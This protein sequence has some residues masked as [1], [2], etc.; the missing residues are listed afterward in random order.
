MK[1]L[2]GVLA[3]LAVL[4][5]PLLDPLTRARFIN[6]WVIEWGFPLLL[7]VVLVILVV[8]F[9]AM[10]RVA[11]AI[12]I[13]VLGIAGLIGYGNARSYAQL[14]AYA[15]TVHESNDPMPTLKERAPFLVA[16]RQASSNL[17]G[18]NGQIS[19][20][21]YLADSNRYSTLVDRKG[22]GNPGYAAI[23]NQSIALTGQASGKPCLFDEQNASQRMDGFFGNS[24]TRAIAAK[25]SLLIATKDDAWGYCDG[26]VPKIVVPVT[27]LNGWFSPVHVPAG[28]A[29]YDGKTGNVEL[30]D[31]VKAGELPGPAIA[32][33]YVHRVNES[34]ATR[35]GDWWSMIMGQSGLT[36]EVKD[37]NDP[38]KDNPSAFSLA[39]KDEPGSVYASPFT[40]RAS[41]RSIEDI[42]LL[43]S[44][45]V[46]AGESPSVTLY[47]LE[48]PRQSNAATA[49]KIK[50]DYSDLNGWATGLQ[51]MEVIPVSHD[52]WAASIGLNQN[53]SYR[54]LVKTDGSS[55]LTKDGETLRCIDKDGKTVGTSTDP[56]KEPASTTAVPGEIGALSNEQLAQLQDAVTKEVL[57]RLNQ[58]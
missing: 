32:L 2:G 33:S 45:H 10:E 31:E 25:D 14:T 5:L 47:H 18:I 17:S 29:I 41:S 27:K 54:V 7:L 24:L 1:V 38:N 44:G 23:I 58:K 21:D 46:K 3:A 8:V 52:E 19:A 26:D 30:R 4:A 6:A 39:Y 57:K 28:V 49:D 11:I 20:T 13:G 48:T 22:M 43:E 51:V 50:A 35:G 34:M 15:A 16:E 37:S 40:S 12:V 55:C 9:A 42:A 56:G 36:D 53:V